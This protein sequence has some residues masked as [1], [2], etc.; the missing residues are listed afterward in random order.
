MAFLKRLGFY[1]IG[2]S[3]GIVFLTVFFKKK[4]EQTGTEFC[5]FPN[6]RTLKDIRSKELTYS[7]AI[8]TLLEE[9]KLDSMDIA[10]FLKN[11]DVDFKNSDTKSVPCRT[12]LIEAPI[13]N[14]K[15][16]LR[17]SNCPK[18]SILEDVRF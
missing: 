6:C 15:A 1:L 9:K 17:V 4:T 7:E 16:V 18:K 10:N 3:I 11:G 12:Y 8:N 2:L 14:K 13:N 5:Y